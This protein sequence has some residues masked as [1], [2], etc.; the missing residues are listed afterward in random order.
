VK[1]PKF[2]IG[3][4]VWWASTESVQKFIQCSD[5]FGKKYLKVELADEP[6]TV[7]T[8]PC[9]GCKRGYREPAGVIETYE[10]VVNVKEATVTGVDVSGEEVEYRSSISST[11]SYLLNESDL[12][13]SR[14]EA[15][16]R[17][18]VLAAERTEAEAARHRDKAKPTHSWAWHVTY[19]RGHLK[20]AQRDVEYHTSQ[21]EYAKSLAKEPK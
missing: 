1:T 3:S 4:T 19:H 7:L 9:E 2:N 15:E 14:A 12:F 8:I 5:C 11:A 18:E 16:A 13:E 21:L 6:P 10:A 17:A 20:R